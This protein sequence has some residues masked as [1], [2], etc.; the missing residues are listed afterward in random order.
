MIPS[1]SDAILTPKASQ[2]R[3]KSLPEA[4]K[5]HPKTQNID[6][7]KQVV[8]R[9]DFFII[10]VWFLVVCWMIFWTQN[11]SKMQKTKT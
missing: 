2:E 9:L 5:M 10:L 6:V 7:K 8:F 11:A 4:S 1:L 3:P